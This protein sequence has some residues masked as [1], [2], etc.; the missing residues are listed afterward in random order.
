MR[1]ELRW[2]KTKCTEMSMSLADQTEVCLAGV[3]N[4]CSTIA[5]DDV[6]A[7]QRHDEAALALLD[8]NDDDALEVSSGFLRTYE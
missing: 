7:V 6:D 2:L 1:S 8:I 4:L 3:L 5:Q